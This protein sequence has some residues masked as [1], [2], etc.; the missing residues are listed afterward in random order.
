MKTS[1]KE[2][3]LLAMVTESTLTDACLVSGISKSTAYR[4]MKEPGFGND[5]DGLKVTL[6]EGATNALRGNLTK[7]ADEL[8]SIAL[9]RENSPQVRINAI[10]QV[11]GIFRQCSEVVDIERKVLELTKEWNQMKRFETKGGVTE[12]E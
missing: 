7:C 12:W 9:N 6:L 11:F 4:Y 8:L 5:L 3:F 10:Q 2:K 1:K